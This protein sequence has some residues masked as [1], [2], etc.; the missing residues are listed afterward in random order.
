[1]RKTLFLLQIHN[2]SDIKHLTQS[3]WFGIVMSG[4]ILELQKAMKA[5]STSSQKESVRV[6][7]HLNDSPRESKSSRASTPD[8][9]FNSLSVA[10]ALSRKDSIKNVRQSSASTFLCPDTLQ[11]PGKLH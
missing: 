1:M 5:L 10:N 3:V 2:K 7:F 6:D 4:N 11:L 8:P 9:Q